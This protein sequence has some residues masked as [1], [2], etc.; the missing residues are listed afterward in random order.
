MQIT[1]ANE[2]IADSLCHMNEWNF[3]NSTV[4]D[5][6]VS[7]FALFHANHSFENTIAQ[8]YKGWIYTKQWQQCLWRK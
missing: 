4:S 7:F 1:V 2:Q 6:L 8:N 3:G 5:L